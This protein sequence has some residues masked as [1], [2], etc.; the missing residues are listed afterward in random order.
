MNFLLLGYLIVV[1]VP[2]L[3]ASWRVSLL[4][5]ALQGLLLGWIALRSHHGL[6]PLSGIVLADCVILR[7]L[8]APKILHRILTTH[9]T[10]RRNDVIPANLF[11]WVLVAG[12]V[13]ASFRFATELSEVQPS[14][15]LHLAT[16]TAALLLALLVLSSQTSMFSQMVGLLRL[17]NA[18]AL[19]ELLPAS[20]ESVLVQLGLSL[21]F[22]LTALLFGRFLRAEL[23]SGSTSTPRRSHV[24]L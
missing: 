16:V 9:N 17:E 21:V 5:L 4:G 7:G 8:V 12:I 22:L 6:S 20:H 1:V 23:R 18:V 2:L 19:F 14:N 3:A 15:P 13:L 11:S 10:P 24:T